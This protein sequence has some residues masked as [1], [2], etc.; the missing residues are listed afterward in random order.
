MGNSEKTFHWVQF[1]EGKAKFSGGIRGGDERRHETFAVELKNTVLYGEIENVFL[2]NGNDYNIE[3]ISFGYGMEANVGNPHP[4]ARG[5]YTF[6]ELQII[7][8]LIVQLLQAGLHFEDRPS[9]LTE[10]PNAHYMGK[11]LFREGWANVRPDS[12]S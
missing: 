2:P 3:V 8:S 11:I 1:K 6:A 5:A 7:K 4:N 10:Y 9:V 12:V